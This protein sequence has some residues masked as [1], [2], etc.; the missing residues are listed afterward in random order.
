MDE[1]TKAQS[2]TSQRSCKEEEVL[3]LFFLIVVRT[4]NMKSILLINF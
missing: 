3:E 2:R 4:L 1:E